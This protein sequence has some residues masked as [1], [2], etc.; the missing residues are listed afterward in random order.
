[1]FILSKWLPMSTLPTH[2]L[3]KLSASRCTPSLPPPTPPT[4]PHPTPKTPQPLR[5]EP[6]RI[7]H[8][9]PPRARGAACRLQADVG[10]GRLRLCGAGLRGA[11]ALWLLVVVVLLVGAGLAAAAAAAAGGGGGGPPAACTFPARTYQNTSRLHLTPP[12]ARRPFPQLY[13][14]TRA[15]A[16]VHQDQVIECVTQRGVRPMLPADAPPPLVK[17][18]NSCWSTDPAARPQFGEIAASLRGMLASIEAG[19]D[20]GNAGGPAAS[21]EDG[22]GASSDAQT[23]S[24]SAMASGSCRENLTTRGS[25]AA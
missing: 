11:Y 13:T 14:G 3:F 4:P 2:S 20:D 25:L 8:H 18:V 17:L 21:P 6:Q 9:H 7:R 1:M 5:P 23:A 24:A 16:G 15:F 10:R 12:P 22:G 19:E